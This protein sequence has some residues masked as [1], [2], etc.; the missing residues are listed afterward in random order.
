M[1]N[2]VFIATSLDGFIATRDGG[3][4]WLDEIPNNSLVQ[5]FYTR[6]RGPRLRRLAHSS[7]LAPLVGQTYT[8]AITRINDWT[9]TRSFAPSGFNRSRMIA[10]IRR[11]RP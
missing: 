7:H 2:R 4:D 9:S 10:A 1:A 6:A 11:N 3:L 5:S 8:A